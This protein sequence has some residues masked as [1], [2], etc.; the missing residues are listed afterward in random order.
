MVDLPYTE[1]NY[2]LTSQKLWASHF[3]IVFIDGGV[4]KVKILTFPAQI[5]L[6]MM[7][8][9]FLGPRYVA[10]A[11][12]P[13]KE[14]FS[15]PLVFHDF[16]CLFLF[17]YLF[18]PVMWQCGPHLT[19]MSTKTLTSRSGRSVGQWHCWM[20][21]SALVASLWTFLLYEEINYFLRSLLDSLLGFLLVVATILTD[22]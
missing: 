18:L 15:V 13:Q 20:V 5:Q 4:W 9:A 6:R 2:Q 3:F 1:G 14:S 16:I 21:A 17:V 10:K 12:V 7:S 8:D 22:I 19:I 11:T